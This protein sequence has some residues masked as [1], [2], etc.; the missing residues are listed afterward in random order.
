MSSD[1]YR[2]HLPRGGD[3]V[4]GF[5]L[6]WLKE[7]VT[8]E[9][10]RRPYDRRHPER[11]SNELLLQAFAAVMDDHPELGYIRYE[12]AM[13]FPQIYMDTD[14]DGN[15]TVSM[16]LDPVDFSYGYPAEE[17]RRIVSEVESWKA[18]I[19]SRV[20]GTDD[21]DRIVSLVRILDSEIIYLPMGLAHTIAG[22]PRRRMVCDGIARTFK[23]LCDAMGIWTIIVRGPSSPEVGGENHTWLITRL[24]KRHYIV[25]PT[26]AMTSSHDDPSGI[27]GPGHRLFSYSFLFMSDRQAEDLYRPSVDIFPSCDD[28]TMEYRRRHGWVAHFNDGFTE[29]TD[30]RDQLFSMMKR[31][32]GDY[33]EMYVFRALLVNP[34]GRHPT[35]E[36]SGRIVTI[37]L[38]MLDVKPSW[39]YTR[40]YDHLSGSF[41]MAINPRPDLQKRRH[42]D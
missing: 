27:L 31:V 17:R 5:L 13:V 8:A 30:S 36:Q 25:D 24:G 7:G 20:R 41:D 29:C 42:S 12:K 23:M 6:E 38:N 1:F 16:H 35:T 40:W 21:Y 10:D 22:I 9:A 32:R 19:L 3:E 2:R 18:G 33:G 4:Y 37:L 34:A 28:D 15:Y 14:Q 39:S 26:F 11:V